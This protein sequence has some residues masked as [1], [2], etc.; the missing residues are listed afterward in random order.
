[1]A[2]SLLYLFPRGRARL[3]PCRQRSQ[4]YA[5]PS[6]T[7]LQSLWFVRSVIDTPEQLYTVEDCCKLLKKS[8]A[9]LY[10]EMQAGRL[11]FKRDGK[12]RKVRASELT[13]YIDAL[14]GTDEPVKQKGR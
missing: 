14:P 11:K 2:P 13:R 10:N 6:A 3:T 1:M 9:A 12:N 5:K 7:S 8:R 4:V